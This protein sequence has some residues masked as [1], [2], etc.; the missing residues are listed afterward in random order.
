L[1]N[2]TWSASGHA[3]AD[4]FAHV[5][6][7]ADTIDVHLGIGN[8]TG[9]TFTSS[10]PNGWTVLSNPFDG[11]LL[12]SGYSLTPMNA[13]DYKIG[14]VS[15]ETGV[16]SQMRLGVDSG[17]S[18]GGIDATPYGYTLAHDTTSANGSYTMSPID[19]GTYA[20]TATRSTSDI[21]NAV[22][23]ADALA[24]LKIAVGMNPN[25]GAVS[26]QLPVSP[27]QIMAADINQDGRI[28]SIDALSI[29][30]MA[31]HMPTAPD[32][33]WVFLDDT[34]DFF[35]D[36]KG[37][38]TLTRSAAAWDH[39]MSTPVQG[40]TTRNLVGLLMGDVDGSWSPPVGTQYVEALQPTYFTNLSSTIHAPVSQW[41]IS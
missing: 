10:L 13:G 19:P 7:A 6:G 21:G 15:F 17:T 23:A 5:T 29:L 24:A 28:S 11:Q 22:T 38:F 14:S 25:A 9:A 36:A 2:I 39:S 3:T 1:K 8:A 33:Q 37:A 20:V 35:D 34:R 26:A 32:P 27:Y 41:G 30:K 12:I 31:V 16:A 4:I 18:V 40:D